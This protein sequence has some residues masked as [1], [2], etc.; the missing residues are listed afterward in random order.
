MFADLF[1][2]PGGPGHPGSVPKHN[3]LRGA[4]VPHIDYGRGDLSYVYGFKEIF[5]RTTASLFVVIAT[6]HYSAAR[7]TLTRKNFKSPLGIVPTDQPYID[8]LVKHYGDGLF[9][10]PYAH[11][12]EH[13][14]ELELVM[15]QYLYE[16][17]RPFRIVPLLVGSF[18]DSVEFETS[19]REQPDIARMI[20]ALKQVEAE[21]EE[22]VCYIVSGDLAHIGPKFGDPPFLSDEKLEDSRVNDLDLLQFA[23]AGDA[24]SYFRLVAGEGDQRRICGLPPTYIFLEAV[25]PTRGKLLQYGQ[26]VH[27]EGFESVSFASVGFYR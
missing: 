22:D 11:F 7:F 19:P 27:P 8:R 9:D 2:M 18:A 21:T 3:Q 25:Q 14:I 6:A 20:A 12:P 16:N 23:A 15:L 1:T 24:E 10:D 26:Y 17:V 5:E 13:S 4:L